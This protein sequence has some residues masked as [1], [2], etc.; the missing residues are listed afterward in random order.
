M[1]KKLL[2][3]VVCV[4]VA[5]G[6]VPGYVGA[7]SPS[8]GAELA[9]EQQYAEAIAELQP[10]LSISETGNIVLNPPE[11]VVNSIDSEV[12][13]ATLAGLEQTNSMIDDGYAVANPDFTVVVTEKF[14]EA[15]SQY[16]EPGSDLIA[17]GNA[18]TLTSSSGGITACYTYS[19]GC[20]VYLSDD[21]CDTIAYFMEMGIGISTI[22]GF[23]LGAAT[24]PA[25]VAWIVDG[26]LI[27]GSATINFFNSDD[28]GI[29]ICLFLY[30]TIVYVG[31]QTDPYGMVA[32]LVGDLAT[33]YPLPYS[34]VM[35]RK[36]G[37]V[38]QQDET[39]YYGQY[40][41][42]LPPG[43]YTVTASHIGFYDKTY[44]VVVSDGA[45]TT[46]SFQLTQKSPGPIPMV[47]LP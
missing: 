30:V 14:R 36:S 32:G 10:Y 11:A 24:P 8:E 9:L 12:Y 43:T 13:Q 26:L 31:P 25:V 5:A 34:T 16:L 3:L 15:C 33:G 4:A 23:A 39:D 40:A 6:L 38:V 17:E 27:M 28:T 46:L 29:E 42:V 21:W 1:I 35:V 19:W 45:D 2:I 18:I 44:T 37:Q 41:I 47:R 22:V 7:A 20:W